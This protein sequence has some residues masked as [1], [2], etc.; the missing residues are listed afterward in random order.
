MPEDNTGVPPSMRAAP[1]ILIAPSVLSADFKR[2]GNEVRAVDAGGRCGRRSTAKALNV[3]L[4][5]I[6][7]ERCLSAFAKARAARS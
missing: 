1:S 6:E 5:I 7:P 2:L 4:M 3:H